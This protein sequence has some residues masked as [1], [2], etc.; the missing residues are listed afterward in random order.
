M[1]VCGKTVG[2]LKMFVMNA[3]KNQPVLSGSGFLKVIWGKCISRAGVS[4][5]LTLTHPREVFCLMLQVLPKQSKA[6]L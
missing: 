4:S 5:L 2:W 3:S 1:G 6:G